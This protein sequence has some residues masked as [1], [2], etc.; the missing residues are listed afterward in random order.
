VTPLQHWGVRKSSSRNVAERFLI[1]QTI[2]GRAELGAI[3]S[4]LE[5]HMRAV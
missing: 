5:E 2:M 3:A 1:D 4:W